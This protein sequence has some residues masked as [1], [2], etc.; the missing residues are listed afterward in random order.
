MC[1]VDKLSVAVVVGGLQHILQV[2]DAIGHISVQFL[3]VTAGF[4]TLVDGGTETISQRKI[5]DNNLLHVQCT[6]QGTP[7][8]NTNVLGAIHVHE[9]CLHVQN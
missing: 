4:R 5:E 6:I 7:I 3:P 2:I 1:D 8:S 9:I